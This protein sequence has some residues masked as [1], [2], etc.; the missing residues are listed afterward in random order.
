VR[1]IADDLGLDLVQLAGNEPP[2][3]VAAIGVPVVKSVRPKSEA[4][5]A[6]ALRYVGVRALL[7][8]AAVGG[9]YGGTGHAADRD[10]ARRLAAE[11]PVPVVLAGGLTAER[12]AEAVAAV[13]PAAVDAASGVEARPGRKDPQKLRA[14]LAAAA[15]L[16]EDPRSAGVFERRRRV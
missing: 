8:D 10:V 12:L 13:R 16:P 7:V 11:S 9:A 4:D 3:D 14:L 2:E 5:G 6:A 1:R 15:R